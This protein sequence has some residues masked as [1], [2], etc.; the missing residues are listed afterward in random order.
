MVPSSHEMAPAIASVVPIV[1]VTTATKNHPGNVFNHISMAPVIR[2][3]G[4]DASRKYKPTIV[5]VGMCSGEVI[6]YIAPFPSDS[7]CTAIVVPSPNLLDRAD[8]LV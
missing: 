1:S 8:F 2:A 5:I 7:G 6:A 4:G 3:S